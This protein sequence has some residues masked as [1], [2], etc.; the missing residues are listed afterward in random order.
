MRPQ[1]AKL[2]TRTEECLVDT[3]RELI[4]AV[5]RTIHVTEGMITLVRS[6]T[7]TTQALMKPVRG[8]PKG[9]CGGTCTKGS[10]H[11]A[12]TRFAMAKDLVR[13]GRPDRGLRL[14]PAGVSVFPALARR[15]WKG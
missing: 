3:E 8:L 4:E 2:L 5:R 12:C 13:V 7:A 15:W 14:G 10:L 1:V 9:G 6:T 11:C